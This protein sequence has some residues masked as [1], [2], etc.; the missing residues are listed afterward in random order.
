MLFRSIVQLTE[1][2]LQ[3]GSTKEQASSAEKSGRKEATEPSAA[4]DRSVLKTLID[5]VGL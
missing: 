5:W 4:T 1:E 3:A 2:Q